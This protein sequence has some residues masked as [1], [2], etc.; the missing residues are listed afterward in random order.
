MHIVIQ[1][2]IENVDPQKT[3]N[4][5]LDDKIGHSEY[6]KMEFYLFCQRRYMPRYWL[7][8]WCQDIKSVLVS[9]VFNYELYLLRIDIFD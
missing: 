7:L 1:K 8:F 6:K 5:I 2:R 9:L 4:S 3:A